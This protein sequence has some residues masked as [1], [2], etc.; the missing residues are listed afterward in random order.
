[1]FCLLGSRPA[2]VPND[3]LQAAHTQWVVRALHGKWGRACSIQKRRKSDANRRERER[4]AQS[5]HTVLT[6]DARASII[7][8]TQCVLTVLAGRT[9]RHDSSSNDRLT[10]GMYSVDIA[11]VA[12]EKK[13]PRAGAHICAGTGLTPAHIYT[14][15][16]RRGEA[17]PVGPTGPTHHHHQRPGANSPARAR[18]E[19]RWMDGAARPRGTRCCA[20]P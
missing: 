5:T 3:R 2:S 4:N 8:D 9:Y 16:R 7:R 10:S 13:W 18:L 19:E 6:Q 17:A 15:A 12:A 20:P 11:T 14:A 1:V